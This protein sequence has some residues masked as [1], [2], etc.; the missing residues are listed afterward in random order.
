M[1]SCLNVDGIFRWR[2]REVFCTGMPFNTSF[3]AV[4][5]F[6][7]LV[8]LTLNF[9]VVKWRF[10]S[11]IFRTCNFV[12]NGYIEFCCIPIYLLNHAI[13]CRWVT[14]YRKLLGKFIHLG[15]GGYLAI[16]FWLTCQKLLGLDI[17]EHPRVHTHTHTTFTAYEHNL[18]FVFCYLLK[19]CL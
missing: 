10:V 4:D 12:F 3:T 8:L 7:L 19:A 5:F 2:G 1:S 14:L 18:I 6:L 9:Q 15:I 17:L 16:I 13:V 11:V